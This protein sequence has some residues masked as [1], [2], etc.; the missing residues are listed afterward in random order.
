MTD[1]KK[2][3]IPVAG[4]GT[5]FLPITKVLPKELL[6]IVDKPSV[7]YVIEEAVASGIETIILVNSRDKK[8]IEAYFMRTPKYEKMLKKLGK[9]N[10]LKELNSF[11]DRFRIETVFQEE[12]KGLG[13]AVYCAK[14]AV[15][16]EPF[17]LLLPD[18]IIESD[19]P[20]SRQLIDVY[21]RIGKSVIYT[22]HTPREKIHL[23]GV[24]NI[25]N[26]VGPLHKL[27]NLV[28]KPSPDKA[29]SDL[30]IVGRYLFTPSIFPLIEKTKP[31]KGGEIQITDAMTDLAQTEGLYA[32]EH[33][34]HVFDTGDKL[35]FMK[36]QL[37][38]G[39]KNPEFGEAIKNYMAQ[40]K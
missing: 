32:F 35:G 2:A 36:A 21:Q 22:E 20:C 14:D 3:V 19:P 1:V 10:L 25:E 39:L 5:R 40:L 4:L 38:F 37:Y 26:S 13:H 31:G 23:Y 11:I 24:L 27:K 16:G 34:A 9:Y 33:E 7:Q 6:P 18:V 17:V 8:L 28:E 30:T 29:P 12:P 15:G